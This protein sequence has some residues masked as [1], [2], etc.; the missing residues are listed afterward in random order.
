MAH[1]AGHTDVGNNI[2]TIQNEPFTNSYEM[3]DAPSVIP[4]P[5]FRAAPDNTGMF[6]P[7]EPNITYPQLPEQP[8]TAGANNM[9]LLSAVGLGI[10]AVGSALGLYN[11]AKNKPEALNYDFDFELQKSQY[12]PNSA[13]QDNMRSLRGLGGEFSQAYRNMLNPMSAYNQRQFQTLRRNVGD[14]ASQ[15]INNM[16]AAMAARGMTGL[17]GAYDAVANANAGDAFARGQLGIINQGANLAG[18]FGGMAM[19]A[20]GQAGQFGSQIDQRTLSNQ[21]FNAQNQ[22]IYNQYLRMAQ[23]NQAR[24]NQDA[25]QAYSNNMTNNLFNIASAGLG[26]TGRRA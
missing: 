15:S 18:Q 7:V 22:N 20:Y 2:V 4:P 6:A 8:Q 21:Q 5:Q 10:G 11:A 1:V 24:A 9:G 13:L 25:Q 19:N 14:T 12:N 26:M 16:N 23:Y 17:S 3:Y